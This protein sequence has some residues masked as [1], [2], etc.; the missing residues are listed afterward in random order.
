[1]FRRLS[2]FVKKNILKNILEDFSLILLTL[3]ARL[4]VVLT[5]YTY[6]CLAAILYKTIKFVIII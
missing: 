3:V 1:M 6:T 5:T 4:H 2:A